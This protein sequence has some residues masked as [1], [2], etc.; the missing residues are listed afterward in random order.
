[1]RHYVF[2]QENWLSP[3]QR[4]GPMSKQAACTLRDSLLSQGYRFVMV[5]RIV[6]LSTNLSTEE[7]Q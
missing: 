4:V 2:Y 6:P 7:V 1:M 5:V 3:D